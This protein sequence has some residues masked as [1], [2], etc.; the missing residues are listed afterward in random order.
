M[1]ES[2]TD[3]VD[4]EAIDL[5][6]LEFAKF[7]KDFESAT[8]DLSK[9]NI[10]KEFLNY[11]DEVLNHKNATLKK[12]T[13]FNEANRWLDREREEFAELVWNWIL[14]QAKTTDSFTRVLLKIC[15][16]E[17]IPEAPVNLRNL[18]RLFD[19]LRDEERQ[20]AVVEA[21]HLQPEKF[22]RDFRDY[23][24]NKKELLSNPVPKEPLTP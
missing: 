4:W 24:F 23:V 6:E 11:L 17:M 7:R 12:T 18:V 19:L 20:W 16:F 5:V 13:V 1:N 3:L 22:Y 10:T 2:N 21:Y 14:E 9:A 8:S 15:I